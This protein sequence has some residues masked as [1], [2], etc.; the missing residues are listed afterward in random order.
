MRCGG[1]LT[2]NRRRVVI[3]TGVLVSAFVFGGIPEMA[4]KKAFLEAEIFVS[5]SLLKEYRVSL[6]R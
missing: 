6:W 4:V 5:P 1:R 2:E 3:D